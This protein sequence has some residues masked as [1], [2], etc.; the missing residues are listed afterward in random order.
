VR[1]GDEPNPVATQIVTGLQEQEMAGVFDRLGRGESL[2]LGE[3]VRVSA[4]AFQ[5]M[6]GRLVELRDQDRVVVLLELLGRTVRAQLEAG[7]VEAA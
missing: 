5:D 1:A 6:I 3:L 7:A 2:R 4:G